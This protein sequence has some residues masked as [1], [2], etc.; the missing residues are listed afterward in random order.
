MRLADLAITM[1][2][3][4]NRGSGKKDAEIQTADLAITL[5]GC[6]K[7]MSWEGGKGKHAKCGSCCDQ[8]MGGGI[9]CIGGREGKTDKEN[10]RPIGKGE[11]ID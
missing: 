11:R 8:G 7:S 1:K 2:M 3:E 4:R 6:R 9:F 5:E 10:A